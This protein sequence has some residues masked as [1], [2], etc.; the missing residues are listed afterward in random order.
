VQVVAQHL[1]DDGVFVLEAFVPDLTRFDR[2]Q[3]MEARQVESDH[4]RF[5]ASVHDPVQQHVM[6]QQVVLAA[7]GIRF[8]PVEI[9]YAWPSELDLMA[10]LAGLQLRHRRARWAEEPFTASNGSH[11]SVYGRPT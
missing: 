6:T 3:Q 1:T 8:Y 11:V 4:V 5:E 9:R 2:G 10:R 7:H